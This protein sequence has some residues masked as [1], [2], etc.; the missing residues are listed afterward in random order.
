MNTK[1]FPV[2][3]FIVLLSLFSCNADFFDKYPIDEPAE[4][5]FY[6][7][8][9]S[10]K[11]VLNDAYFTLR[12]AYRNY[13]VFGDLASDDVYNSKFNNSSNHITINESNV[14]AD[15]GLVSAMWDNAYATISRTNLVLD[16]IEGIAMSDEHR[17][18]YLN[19]AKFLRALMYF[20]LV[21]IYGDV[22]LVLKDMEEP[23][24]AFE[25]GR[26][27][28][29]EVYAQIISDLTDAESLPES[30]TNNQDIGRAT[31]WAAKTLLAKVHLTL[32][33]YRE[34]DSKLKEVLTSTHHLLP[35]YAAVFAADNPNNEEIIF[36]VQ[37]ARGFDPSQ[38]NPFVE[39]AFANEDIGMG[40]LKR[41]TGTFLMTEEL[42]NEFMPNDQRTTMIESLEGSRRRY[43]F[44][45]KYYDTGMTSTVDAGNDWIVLR[46][47]DVCLMYAEVQ[48]ELGNTPEALPYLREVRDRAGLNTDPG[49]ANAPQ[50][51]RLAI[52]H[53]RRLELFCEGHRWFDLLRTGRLQQVMNTHFDSSLS[54]DEIGTNSNIEDYELLFPIPRY[55]IN[56][57][58]D[59]IKQNTGY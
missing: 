45:M 21:R 42:F 33:Q 25:F 26:T 13:F 59:K 41:G 46:Y 37:Y 10:I 56:L 32:K 12:E 28:Q 1:L 55:Q 58:P 40:V 38:G 30:Y 24:E 9:E 54:N 16:H 44:T 4:D 57:N 5:N 6:Q 43:I 52:E 34:A 8:E 14:V 23:S 3:Y 31:K 11:Q 49:L 51:M 48:N 50:A 15:N 35:S 20:N 19:E 36:A 53:E 17:S 18:Q 27:S 7:D 39:G 47:A 22:P 2:I 29:D